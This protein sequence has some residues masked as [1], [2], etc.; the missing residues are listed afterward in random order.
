VTGCETTTARWL[1]QLLVP[2]IARA[3]LIEPGSLRD[4]GHVECFNGTSGDE[5]LGGEI[6]T[7]VLEARGLIADLSK[8]YNQFQP[9]RS[10]PYGPP[11][12]EDTVLITLAPSPVLAPWRVNVR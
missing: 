2:T 5:L 10:P 12:P 7:T 6:F 11:I 4:N 9:H 1:C 8:E 3:L